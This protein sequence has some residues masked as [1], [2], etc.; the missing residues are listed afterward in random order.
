MFSYST[1]A[2][3]GAEEHTVHGNT[4]TGTFFSL[5]KWKRISSLTCLLKALLHHGVNISNR[6]QEKNKNELC[7]L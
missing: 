1:A 5:Q 7:T 4:G 6:L 3:Q 2:S